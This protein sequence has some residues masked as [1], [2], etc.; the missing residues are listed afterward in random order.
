MKLVSYGGSEVEFA[1][2]RGYLASG[3]WAT[4][5]M[6][7]HANHGP[8]VCF[9]CGITEPIELHHRTYENI[10]REQIGLDIVPLCEDHHREVERLIRTTGV[11][12][13]DAHL[14]YVAL[15]AHRRG[16]LRRL[17]VAA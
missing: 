6:L 10:G 1:S 15:L 17:A 9:V 13:Y 8:F 5:R 11:A 3:V 4:Q 14:R 16:E 12:R 7:L 2:A